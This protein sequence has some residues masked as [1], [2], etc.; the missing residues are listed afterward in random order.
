[1]GNTTRNS[2]DYMKLIAFCLLLISEFAVEK[3][4]FSYV[5]H[6]TSENPFW[7]GALCMVIAYMSYLNMVPIH[8]KKYDIRQLAMTVFIISKVIAQLYHAK[9]F[10]NAWGL[11]KVSLP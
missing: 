11:K 4:R 6:N 3:W 1:M 5:L 8:I 2:G 10:L 7:V 9:D